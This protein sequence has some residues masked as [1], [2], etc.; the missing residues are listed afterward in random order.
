MFEY[1]GKVSEDSEK[2]VEELYIWK[3]QHA[4]VL[5]SAVMLRLK[6]IL[7]IVKFYF[8]FPTFIPL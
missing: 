5:A 3:G 1:W 4:R 2:D 6:E 8:I 7:K